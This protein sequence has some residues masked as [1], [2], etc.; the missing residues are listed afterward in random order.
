MTYA[1]TGLTTGEACTITPP[2]AD[3]DCRRDEHLDGCDTTTAQFKAKP[4]QSAKQD[5]PG[6]LG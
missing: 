4:V 3:V 6:S 1:C 2:T 5:G